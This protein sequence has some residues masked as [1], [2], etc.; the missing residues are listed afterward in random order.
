ML[1]CCIG[2]EGLHDLLLRE[3]ARA[4][5]ARDAQESPVFDAMLHVLLLARAVHDVAAQLSALPVGAVPE[6]H[7]R[8]AHRTLTRWRS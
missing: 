7:L 2:R 5:R 3:D 6:S 4:Q 8:L 1:T